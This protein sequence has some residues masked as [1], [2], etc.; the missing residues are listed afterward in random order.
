MPQAYLRAFGDAQRQDVI[1]CNP[2]WGQGRF[3]ANL[4]H[5]IVEEVIIAEISVA[6]QAIQAMQ[7]KFDFESRRSDHSP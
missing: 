1:A 4:L 7:L 2:W 3:A 6:V 5:E